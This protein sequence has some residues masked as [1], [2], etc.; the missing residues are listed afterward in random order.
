MVLFASKSSLVTAVQVSLVHL[1]RGSVPER[2][3]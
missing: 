3:V 1:G 2:L